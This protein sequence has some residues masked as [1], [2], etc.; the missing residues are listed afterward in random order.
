[1]TPLQMIRRRCLDCRGF[2][3]KAVR[4]CDMSDCLLYRLRMGK[5]SRSTLKRIRAYCIDCCAGQ[6]AEVKECAARKC[7]LW[8]YRMGRRPQTGQ[9]IAKI[10]SRAAGSLMNRSPGTESIYPLS[11]AVNYP[12]SGG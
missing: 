8:L 9:V 4:E 5:G 7:S 6:R 11:K 3:A 10:A 12:L 2:E 1:M